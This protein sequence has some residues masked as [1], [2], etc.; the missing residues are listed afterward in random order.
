[1][2]GWQGRERL[3]TAVEETTKLG[4]TGKILPEKVIFDLCFE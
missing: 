4:E 1:M 3:E 2:G